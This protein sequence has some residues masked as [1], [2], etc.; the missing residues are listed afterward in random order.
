M[1]MLKKLVVAMVLVGSVFAGNA[2]A[3]WANVG[4][5]K[6]YHTSPLNTLA[7]RTELP[8]PNSPCTNKD[9]W[10]IRENNMSSFLGLIMVAYKNKESIRIVATSNTECSGPYGYVDMIMVGDWWAQ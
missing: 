4:K 7:F 9:I 10:V 3:N 1:K 5:V 6:S 2:M 8:H